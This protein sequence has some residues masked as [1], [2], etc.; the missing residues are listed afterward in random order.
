MSEVAPRSVRLTERTV[1]SPGAAS[2]LPNASRADLVAARPV[3]LSS[4]PKESSPHERL[5]ALGVAEPTARA[6]IVQHGRARVVDALDALDTLGDGEVRRPAGWVISA[7]RQGWDLEGILAERRQ[8]EARYA[9]RERERAER[10]RAAAQWR[11]RESTV[12]GWRAALSASL[13]AR[14]AVA[15]ARV[16][17]PVAGLGRR[18]LPIVR[19]QLLMWAVTKHAAA[20]DRPLSEVLA[21]DL[22]GPHR[23]VMLRRSTVRSR[24]SPAKF[25]SRRTTSPNGS[26]TCWRAARTSRIPARRLTSGRTTPGHARSVRGSVMAADPPP[27]LSRE[28]ARER[29]VS[30]HE[31]RE[32]ANSVEYTLTLTFVVEG[33]PAG[34]QH[35]P[36]PAGSP[37]GSQT[38][39]PEPRASWTCARSPAHRTTASC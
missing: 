7:I 20:P 6:L 19:A 35:T 5:V 22:V 24:R 38:P 15:V 18:A 32:F 30:P 27:D 12:A 37:N 8:V 13:D 11:A 39:P 16:T 29:A 9:R 10:D 25:V 2:R 23:T 33:G 36:A 1:R 31:V 28:P 14:L 26:H 34:G 17:S 21:D 3:G 4:S